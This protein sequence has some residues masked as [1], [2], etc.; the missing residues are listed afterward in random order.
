MGRT[1]RDM[2]TTMPSSKDDL[3]SHSTY[4]WQRLET[5]LDGLTDEE[6]LWSPIPGCWSIHVLAD[7][8][9]VVDGDLW[10]GAKPPFTNLA[11]RIAHL[12]DI[13]GS[14]RTG[15]WLRAD[16]TA[17]PVND[18]GWRVEPTAAGAVALLKQAAAYWHELLGAVSDDEL[19]EL[20]GP[21]GGQYADQTLRSFVLHQ[22]DEAIHHAA[23]VG[24]L[25][26]LYHWTVVDALEQPTLE[27]LRDDPR[28]VTKAAELGR[29]D[30][31]EQLVEDGCE[32][33]GPAP[34]ALHYAAATGHLSVVRSLVDHGAAL[35]GKDPQWDATPLQWALAFGRNPE[36]I[37]FLE[38]QSS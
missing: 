27:S 36:L 35:D 20:L 14:A 28:A 11:W 25:R 31:V 34:T 10:Q 6:Y 30:L 38:A 1:V 12:I 2:M 13:Y 32:V 7:D 23:E 17:P 33:N 37:E 22:L 16:V 18:K 3:I 24:V 4:T 15:R 26:D 29:W 21:T 8:T 9:W 19:S 5:R